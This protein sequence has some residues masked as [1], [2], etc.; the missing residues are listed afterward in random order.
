[1][2][3]SAESDLARRKRLRFR[4]AHRGSKELDLILGPFARRYVDNFTTVQLDRYERLLEL[5]EPELF[6]WL[7]GQI[8]VPHAERNDVV[9]MLLTFDPTQATP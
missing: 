1:M 8:E 4:S 7:T 2:T 5:P 6:G 9:E 3:D